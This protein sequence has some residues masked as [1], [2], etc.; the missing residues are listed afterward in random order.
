M[1]DTNS[2]H[3]PWKSSQSLW[4]KTGPSSAFSPSTDIA[5][6][7]ASLSGTAYKQLLQQAAK[8]I[9]NAPKASMSK[10]R[11]FAHSKAISDAH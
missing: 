5:T 11:A 3:K 6:E 9:I 8:Q 10:E 7:L 1:S 2:P 4:G